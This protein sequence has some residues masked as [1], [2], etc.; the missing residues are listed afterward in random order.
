MFLKSIFIFLIIGLLTLTKINGYDIDFY[1]GQC[2]EIYA[3]LKSQGKEKNFYDCGEN[4]KGEVIDLSLYPFSLKNEQLQ[5]VLSYNTIMDLS[6]EDCPKM[7]GGGNRNKFDCDSIPT[8]YE[9]LKTLTNLKEFYFDGILDMSDNVF[10][11]IPKS[12]ELLWIGSRG[13]PQHL[14]LTQDMVDRLSKLT[15]LKS[16]TIYETEISENLNFRKF[17][18]LKKLSTLKM[19]FDEPNLSSFPNYV[20]GNILKYCKNLKKLII[21]N[22]EFDEN[23]LNAIGYLTKL[24]ELTLENPKFLEETNFTSLKKLKNLTFLELRCRSESS[25]DVKNLS[26]NFFS[27]TKLR[28]FSNIDC[29]YQG[30][31]I[32]TSPENSLTWANLKNLDYIRM[33]NFDNQHQKKIFDIKYLADIPS[34]KEVHIQGTGY[35]S[36]PE[37]IENLQNLEVLKI[38][39]NQDLVDSLPKSIVNLEKLR[40]LDIS[41][42]HITSLP[43][44]IGNLKNLRELTFYN[45]GITSLPESIGNLAHLYTL[46]GP[47]NEITELPD[48]IGNLTNLMVIN[49]S[50]NK[51]SKL[52]ESM[53]NLILLDTLDISNNYITE[54]PQ[55]IHNLNIVDYNVSNQTILGDLPTES[56][57]D[58]PTESMEDIPTEIIVDF[59]TENV[60]DFPTENVEEE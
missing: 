31:F 3:Y 29:G 19:T 5:K 7:Y 57:E 8:N 44:E 41:Y 28:T 55:F 48:S 33:Y 30:D 37:N 9:V 4:N 1:S 56:V 38:T 32:P 10:P 21:E 34:L 18:N 59:P 49:L 60:E 15:N 13:H 58:F 51:I 22:G 25:D 12:V 11:N 47:E 16:L 54:I 46:E 2:R 42:N 52:P 50:H 45:N 23:N 26:P 17:K 20:Q 40:V 6:F 39:Y 43:D 53:K 27:L 35:S 14:K 36:I 24:N